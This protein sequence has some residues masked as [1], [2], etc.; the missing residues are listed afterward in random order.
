MCC[1][2]GS[3]SFRTMPRTLPRCASLC[4][5]SQFRFAHRSQQIITLENGKVRVAYSLAEGQR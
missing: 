4:P 2:S 3:S 1:S 5:P